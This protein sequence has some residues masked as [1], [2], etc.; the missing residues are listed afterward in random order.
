MTALLVFCLD[1]ADLTHYE[2]FRE[3][4]PHLERALTY[5]RALPST[6][7]PQTPVAWTS[8][9]TGLE[10]EASGVW[11]WHTLNEHRRLVPV[12][13]DDLPTAWTAWG[14][15]RV[16][17]A[18]LPFAVDAQ[19]R[20]GR[21]LA[22]LR[23]PTKIS[24][25]SRPRLPATASFPELLSLWQAHQYLWCDAVVQAS[26]GHD[27]V[28]VHCDVVDWFSHRLGPHDERM[29][30]AWRLADRLLGALVARL[31]PPSTV[32]VSDHGSCQTRAFVLAH[33]AL[34]S[35]GLSRVSSAQ[36]TT[37]EGFAEERVRLIGD[38]GALWL[39]DEADAAAS[40]E[41]MTSLGAEG[42]TTVGFGERAPSLVFRF[43]DGW[44][45][46]LPPELYPREP[47]EPVLREGVTFEHLATHNWRGDHAREGLLG[48]DQWWLLEACDDAPLN[49]LRSRLLASHGF[50]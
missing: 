43:P 36:V 28:L 29:V 4:L 44:I 41:V 48:S 33:D 10:P 15:A 21:S 3:G 23:G 49:G 14:R 47:G 40:V 50:A 9:M 11:G 38:Y 46:L 30:Q 22:G 39:A 24:A 26:D 12:G 20:R 31:R 34:A 5:S 7:V 37:L 17:A 13:H 1:G 25:G 45:T 18:G 2:R 27:V 8:F 35:A 42:H 16:L 6:V 32:T 19:G